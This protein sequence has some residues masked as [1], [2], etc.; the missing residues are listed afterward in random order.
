[1]KS[2][3][4][5]ALI[6]VPL[7][8]AAPKK[9]MPTAVAT[10]ERVSGPV[11]HIRRKNETPVSGETS[12]FPGDTVRLGGEARAQ[13]QVVGAHVRLIPGSEVGIGR[14]SQAKSAPWVELR[15]GALEVESQKVLVVKFDSVNV[16]IS[17]GTAILDLS[18]PA[19]L[20]V[21]SGSARVKAG[22]SDPVI[23][24]AGEVAR[25]TAG[26]LDGVPEQVG[27]EQI[28]AYRKGLGF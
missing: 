18:D 28:Q 4:V 12:L 22:V 15:T 16:E 2:A 10:L 20:S 26:I 7:A 1:M 8:F 5:L 21:I 3:F 13:L 14:S 23:L 11:L 25:F 19:R 9:K 17:G 24:K 6:L 27:V